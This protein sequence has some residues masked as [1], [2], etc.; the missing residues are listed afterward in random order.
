MTKLPAPFALAAGAAFFAFLFPVV[1]PG[2]D[3]DAAKAEAKKFEGAWHSQTVVVNGAQQGNR[4]DLYIFSGN[5]WTQTFKGRVVAEGTFTVHER[6]PYWVID[7]EYTTPDNQKGKHWHAIY[8]FD[9]DTIQW[10][11]ENTPPRAPAF[12]DEAY[13]KLPKTFETKPGDGQFMR[14]VKRMK[15]K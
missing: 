3:E 13:K 1:S 2:A 8:R 10:L 12:N 6:K 11:G 9:G 4:V 7:F 15:D 5:K 14:T